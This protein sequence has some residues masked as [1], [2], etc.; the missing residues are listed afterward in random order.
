MHSDR[1]DHEGPGS[2]ALQRAAILLQVP[3]RDARPVR[4]DSGGV[5][6]YRRRSGAVQPGAEI[7]PD[8]AAEVH[9]PGGVHAGFI[10]ADTGGR[11]AAQA[12]RESRAGGDPALESRAP[13]HREDGLRRLLPGG[14]GFHQL[15]P[16]PGHPGGARPRVGGRIAG[17]V[18]P[19]HHQHRPPAL[20]PAL[21]AVPKPRAD[22]HAGHGHRLLL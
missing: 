11:G 15:C 19:G 12:I 3:G 16:I 18:L 13:G 1:Q 7:R 21:R 6:E 14:L 2:L 20:R 9:G 10:L 17:R 5:E 8:P 22:Q 4:R